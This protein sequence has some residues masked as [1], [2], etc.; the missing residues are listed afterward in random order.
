MSWGLR[1]LVM[2]PRGASALT[3]GHVVLGRDAEAL[4]RTRRHERVHVA[5]YERW[6]PFFLPAYALAS[7][8]AVL[9]GRRAYRDNAFEREAYAADDCRGE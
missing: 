5:Q 3:L 6:G 2:P 9:S 7:L 8:I 4:H 1:R